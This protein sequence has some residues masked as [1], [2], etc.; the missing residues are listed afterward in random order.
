MFLI[1]LVTDKY[2][3]CSRTE[4]RK[5]YITTKELAIKYCQEETAKL[6][7][8]KNIGIKYYTCEEIF[9]VYKEKEQKHIDKQIDDMSVDDLF[10]LLDKFNSN[11]HQ[12]TEE[13]AYSKLSSSDL[14]ELFDDDN[15]WN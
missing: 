14:D 2:G 13:T 5:G 15:F 1:T 12:Q 9:D 11:K 6:I 8:D 7:Y 3:V 10:G 4:Q